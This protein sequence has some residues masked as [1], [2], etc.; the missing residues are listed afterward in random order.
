MKR[1]FI[2]FSVLT[3]VLACDRSYVIVQVAYAQ[4][5]FTAAIN[6]QQPGADGVLSDEIIIL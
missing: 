4:L 1:L 5:G 2:M 3:S 6:G